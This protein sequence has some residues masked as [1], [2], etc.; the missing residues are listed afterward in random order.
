MNKSKT[1]IIAI[2]LSLSAGA[3]ADEHEDGY[4]TID[5]YV[6]AARPYLHFSC[7]MNLLARTVATD[8]YIEIV[9][10]LAAIGFINHD[11]D[12]AEMDALPA[13][14]L[15]TVQ[16]EYY[17]EIGR[18]CRESPSMLLVGVVENALIDTFSSLRAE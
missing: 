14:E 18:Q 10:K 3:V 12:V 2:F 1:F 9:N 17:N 7:E 16:I 11:F 15:E 8:A 13:E 4:L 6:E 5:E